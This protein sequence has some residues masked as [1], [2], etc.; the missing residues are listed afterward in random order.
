MNP[1]AYIRFI[2]TFYGKGFQPISIL[3]NGKVTHIRF[4]LQQRA[5]IAYFFSVDK[6]NFVILAVFKVLGLFIPFIEK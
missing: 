6:E 5:W 1:I 4:F 2:T 3:S